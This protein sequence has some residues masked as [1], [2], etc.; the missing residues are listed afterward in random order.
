[1]SRLREVQPISPNPAVDITDKPLSQL[2]PSYSQYPVSPWGFDSPGFQEVVH[3]CT[4]GITDVSGVGIALT[5]ERRRS[6][7]NTVDG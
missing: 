1:M 5:A 6:A 7:I 4:R 2:T 3:V